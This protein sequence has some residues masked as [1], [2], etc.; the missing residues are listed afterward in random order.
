MSEGEVAL[1]RQDAKVIGLVGLAHASSHFYHLTL[2]AL[3]PVLKDAF[4]VSYTAL[5]L[6]LTVFFS[7]SGFAQV[8]AGFAVDHW[9][10][11]RVLAAGVALLGISAIL[12]GLA[13]AF[14]VLFPI[15]VLAGIG[16]A[17]FHPADLAILTHRVTPTRMARAYSLHT[18]MGTLGWAASPVTMILLSE[19]FGWR[20]ALI[21]VGLVFVALAAA[22][23]LEHRAL[24]A[25][26][27]RTPAGERLN[28]QLL[29]AP[30]IVASFAFFALLALALS[31][32]QTFMPTLL[33]LAQEISYPLAA[34]ATTVYLVASAVG[35]LAG[36]VLADRTSQHERVVAAGLFGAG[37]LTLVVGF[38]PMSLPALF[39]VIVL[40][41]VL[42]GLTVPS[43]DMLV[44]GATPPGATGKVFGF[45]YSGLDL[46]SVLAP[47]AIGAML[48]GGTPRAAFAFMAAALMATIASAQFVKGPGRSTGTHR[49]GVRG[50]PS[51]LQGSSGAGPLPSPDP[52]E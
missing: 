15:A 49:A 8:A 2:P 48:D 12:A 35:S 1:P 23:V 7:V 47:L 14:W 36:G 21:A 19:R 40:L 43:R 16:N 22:L 33:P 17:V 10:P 52:G 50:E 4:E 39:A 45:V 37:A 5:G 44:R 41:G 30:A 29:L 9:G 20:A 31:G 32:T 28:W 6:T 25:P 13:P 26:V 42:T 11:P 24:R 51:G 46:G 3:F 18:V 34:T 27:H 38:V